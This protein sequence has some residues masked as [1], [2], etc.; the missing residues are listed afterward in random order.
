MDT[1][2][3]ITY[4]NSAAESILGLDRKDITARRYNDPKWKIYSVNGSLVNKD[5]LP[6]S[7]VK[8]TDKPVFGLEHSITHPDGSK[9]FLSINAAPLHDTKGLFNGVIASISDITD[10]V[11]AQKELLESQN[12]FN[13][14]M[15]YLPGFAYIKDINGRHIYTNERFKTEMNINP[16]DLNGKTNID[17]WNGST[18]QQLTMH[19]NDVIQKGTP[20]VFEESLNIKGNERIFISYKFPIPAKDG[21]LLLGG[22]S[23]DIT[24]QKRLEDQLMHSQKME[25]VGT[26]AGG[27]AHDFNN[28]LTAILGYAH[29]AL[30]KLQNDEKLKQHMER[31]IESSQKAALLTQRL[32]AFS[33]KQTLNLVAIDANEIIRHF[34]QLILR[35]LPEN[36][37]LKISLT[38]EPLP[39]LADT[40]Q[41][42][43]VL[44]N[45]STNARD[46]MPD[47]G[48]LEISAANMVDMPAYQ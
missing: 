10:R 22:I 35:L 31:I 5:D 27:V 13:M 17:I 4:A 8:N 14:F 48:T 24:E 19:D 20:V 25:A 33:R 26:L 38:N 37:E 43:Q 30:M 6:F 39:I 41:I 9:A 12:R 32:L 2:G 34:E 36:I 15:K 45:L 7:L 28:I 46:A 44:M 47:G 1:E 23:I 21:S 11:N 16:E 3:N 29:L 18:A 42:E 40:T